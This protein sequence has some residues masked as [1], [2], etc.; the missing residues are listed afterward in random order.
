M[1]A[2]FTPYIGH[3][4]PTNLFQHGP[5][6]GPGVAPPWVL[7]NVP[8]RNR[9]QAPGEKYAET[10]LPTGP[11][12]TGPV[13]SRTRSGGPK[14]TTSLLTTKLSYAVAQHLFNLGMR[15][16]GRRWGGL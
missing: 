7:G 10:D 9:L 3:S 4:P 14:A 1:M 5:R 12:E 6:P 16:W 11:R 15:G 2:P 13:W 8:K